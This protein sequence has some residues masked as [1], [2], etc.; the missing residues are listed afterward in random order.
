VE[1]VRKLNST[2]QYKQIRL[3]VMVYKML[4]L[5]TVKEKNDVSGDLKSWWLM[6]ASVHTM[7]RAFN[8]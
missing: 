6:S 4:C 1:R 2:L 8:F 7:R 5:H 3:E